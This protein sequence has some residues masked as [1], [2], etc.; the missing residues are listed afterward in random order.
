[1]DRNSKIEL[2]TLLEEKEHRKKYR[3]L[4]SFYPDE[5]PLRRELYPKHLKFF[6]GGAQFRE[7]LLLGGNRTGKTEGTGG[8]EFVYHMTGVYPTWWKGRRFGQPVEG[9]CAGTTAEATR[10]IIQKKLMGPREAL[11]TGLIP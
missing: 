4:N 3:K 9:W 7:R 1:M 8:V 5:G 11:G 10:D 6:E 2:L